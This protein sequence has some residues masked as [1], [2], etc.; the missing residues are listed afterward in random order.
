M[1]AMTFAFCV[2]CDGKEIV[3]RQLINITPGLNLVAGPNGS[4]KSTLLRAIAGISHDGGDLAVECNFDQAA[5]EHKFVRL[6][7]QETSKQLIGTTLK[8]DLQITAKLRNEGEHELTAKFLEEWPAYQALLPRKVGA[9]SRGELQRFVASLATASNA[10]MVC[11]DEPD[12]FLDDTGINQLV[13]ST[14]VLVR[15]ADTTSSWIVVTHRIDEWL[16][17]LTSA[18]NVVRMKAADRNTHEPVSVN[19]SSSEE[20]KLLFRLNAGTSVKIGNKKS[21]TR[22]PVELKAGQG[23]MLFGPNG[24]GKTRMMRTIARKYKLAVF[25]PDWS[26]DIGDAR[27]VS[28]LDLTEQSKIMIGNFGISSNDHIEQLSWGQKR[29]LSILE[30]L[31]MDRPAKLID[32]PF[33]GLNQDARRAVVNKIQHSV[34]AGQSVMVASNREKDLDETFFRQFELIKLE[35][36]L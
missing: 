1:V 9:V 22:L 2:R 25:L 31:D 3:P 28:G 12:S 33:A 27:K 14:E 35:Q 29:L 19:Q 6:L 18:P 15:R 24:S 8:S 17:T 21:K 16:K 20:H 10:R 34:A 4:G 32:E 5:A 7:P 36:L 26:A 13:R 11:L 30:V 23:A